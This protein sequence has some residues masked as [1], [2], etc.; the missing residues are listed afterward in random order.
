MY[1][2]IGVAVDVAVVCIQPTEAV[3]VDVFEVVTASPLAAVKVPPTTVEDA[4]DTKPAVWVERPVTPSVPLVAKFPFDAVVVAYPFTETSPLSQE[5]PE[6]VIRVVEAP[7]SV[8]AP[9]TVSVP[10]V[11]KFPFDAVVVAYPFTETS[12]LSQELLLTETCVV[13]AFT[14]VERP[15]TP[16]V[17]SVTMFVLMVVVACTVATTK[18]TETTTATI[19][20]QNPSLLNIEM[21]FIFKSIS[22]KSI[23]VRTLLITWGHFQL[24]LAKNKGHRIPT[25]LTLYLAKRKE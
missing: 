12:P 4:C 19:T 1:S 16:R 17:P 13:D 20:G 21:P 18:N 10:A 3:D 7:A 11:A 6:F 23:N 9:V 24:A 22:L 25:S 15:V 14:S 2:F 5:A 8:E